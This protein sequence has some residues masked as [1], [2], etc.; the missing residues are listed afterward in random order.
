MN[1]LS[2]FWEAAAFLFTVV[3]C[4][5]NLHCIGV[6][7]WDGGA[8]GSHAMPRGSL[9]GREEFVEAIWILLCF[10]IRYRYYISCGYNQTLSIEEGNSFIGLQS[11]GPLGLSP[12][13]VVAPAAVCCMWMQE[14]AESWMEMLGAGWRCKELPVGCKMRWHRSAFI[15]ISG[16]EWIIPVKFAPDLPLSE[17]NT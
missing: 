4:L 14:S 6:L 3:A 12:T 8:G 5:A 2:T 10:L 15:F 9:L 16:V 11:S 7:R 17:D 1:Y 13:H